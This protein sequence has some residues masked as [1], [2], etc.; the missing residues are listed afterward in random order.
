MKTTE[1]NNKGK[2]LP[3]LNQGKAGQCG[4]R[5]ERSVDTALSHSVV[6]HLFLVD[7]FF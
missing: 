7:N 1:T 6:L 3:D 4:P 2:I 5:R